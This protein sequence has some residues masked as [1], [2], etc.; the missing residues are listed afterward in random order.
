MIAE[1]IK[2]AVPRATNVS[3]DLSTVRWTD[4]EKKL[5]YTYLTPR[6]A[7]IAL[8]AMTRPCRPVG[9]RLLDRIITGRL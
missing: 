4:P 1:A 8:P 5:R 7:Q 9:K 2:Q 6:A 3:V